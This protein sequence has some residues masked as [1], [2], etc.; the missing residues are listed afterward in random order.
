M[1][2]TMAL[3]PAQKQAKYRERLVR[4]EERYALADA[5]AVQAHLELSAFPDR[6]GTLAEHQERARRYQDFL[7]G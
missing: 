2:N 7:A 6:K 1:G 3:T 4:Q 5:M